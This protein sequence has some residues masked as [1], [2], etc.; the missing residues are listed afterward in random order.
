[1][2]YN[3]YV[4]EITVSEQRERSSYIIYLYNVL[5]ESVIR[6]GGSG[7]LLFGEERTGLKLLLPDGAERLRA[8]IAAQVGEVIGIGY[9]YEF[10]RNGLRVCLS[11]R[12]KKLLCAA[13][14]AADYDG[15]KGYI[16]RKIG[17]SDQYAIDGIYAFRMGALREKWEKIVGYVPEGFASSDLK[18]FCDFMVGE[19]KN[20]IYL[21]GNTVFGEN[22]APLRR[23]RLTGEEDAETEILL[24]DAGFVYCLGDVEDSLGD[25][26]QKYYAER[27]IFS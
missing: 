24:S 26:L 3:N 15:D 27:A 21:R 6:A 18:K 10:L 14:I 5:S 7:E 8:R 22:F 1:M 16:R 11:K 25:F 13:L 20:K 17:R 19:S 2:A 9:K 12:E 4:E 23:S